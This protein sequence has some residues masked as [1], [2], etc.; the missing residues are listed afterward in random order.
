MP[1]VVL[2]RSDAGTA[3]R[4]GRIFPDGCM[5]LIW[6]GGRL[7]VAGPDTKARWHLAAPNAATVGLRF[8]RGTGPTFLGTAADAVRDVTTGL[9]GV[10]PAADARALSEEAAG[11]AEGALE[12]WLLRR[13]S[14]HEPPLLGAAVFAL[15]AGGMPVGAMAEQLGYSVRQLH[16]RCLPL[17][18]YGPQHLRRVL[19]FQRV[20]AA[21][22]AGLPLA[23]TAASAGFAD[24][25]HLSR[26]VK[27]L[28]GTTPGGLVGELTG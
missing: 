20:L 10:W 24:Q 25:A 2:W 27:Q 12:R 9:D 16:R 4:P 7:V 28:A 22:Q 1:G 15:A 21:A 8:S 13:A 26:D 11:D 18:G 23:R 14:D 17:F 19:R 3:P 5:D 6:D